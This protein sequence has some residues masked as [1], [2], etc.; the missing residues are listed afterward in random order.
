MVFSSQYLICVV[1]FYGGIGGTGGTIRNGAV[2]SD[3]T[4]FFIGGTGGTK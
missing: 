3:T 4:L 1:H 2:S